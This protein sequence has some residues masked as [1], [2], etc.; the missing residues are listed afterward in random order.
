MGPLPKA[1]LSGIATFFGVMLAGAIWGGIAG[2]APC[3]AGQQYMPMWEQIGWGMMF[4]ALFVGAV[5]AWPAALVTAVIVGFYWNG[6][7]RPSTP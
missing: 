2:L 7:S 6:K 3:G 4:G 1:I 5:A